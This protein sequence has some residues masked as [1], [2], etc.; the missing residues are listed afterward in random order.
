MSPILGTGT[1]SSLVCEPCDVGRDWSIAVC[2]VDTLNQNLVVS[3]E[4]ENENELTIGSVDIS[5][6]VPVRQKVA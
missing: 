2:F 6:P 3:C 5:K 4:I 1:T